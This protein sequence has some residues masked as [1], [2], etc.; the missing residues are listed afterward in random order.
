MLTM[1]LNT[2]ARSL[3]YALEKG[4]EGK[5]SEHRSRR[6][7]PWTQAMTYGSQANV[8]PNNYCGSQ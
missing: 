5:H 4:L 1:R 7:V 2:Q 8:G 6:L 3:T